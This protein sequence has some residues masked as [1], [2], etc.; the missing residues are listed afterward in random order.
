MCFKNP[1][2]LI[3][4]PRV[5]SPV[6]IV[7]SALT[8]QFGGNRSHQHLLLLTLIAYRDASGRAYYYNHA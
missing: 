3:F 4:D 6:D 2:S 8:G 5:S 7:E 1:V